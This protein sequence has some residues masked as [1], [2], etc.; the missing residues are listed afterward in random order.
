[1]LKNSH[2]RPQAWR[3]SGPRVYYPEFE[4]HLLLQCPD[5]LS[6]TFFT[7]CTLQVSMFYPNPVVFDIV[8]QRLLDAGAG[9]CNHVV[10]EGDP[11]KICFPCRTMPEVVIAHF[12]ACQTVLGQCIG[13]PRACTL[14]ASVSED[15]KQSW[16]HVTPQSKSPFSIQLYSNTV[17]KKKSVSLSGGSGLPM[18]VRCARRETTTGYRSCPPCK[19][20]PYMSRKLM[21]G[22][23][24]C[25]KKR[26]GSWILDS[27][28][29]PL[30]PDICILLLC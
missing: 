12:Y 7:T 14:C 23:F 21:S 20:N 5:F 17:L 25:N 4:Y 16:Y 28:R 24:I 9:I 22:L 13:D 1:M 10:K 27:I 29:T 30:G 26:G 11:H 19:T 18:V 15:V 6:G 3:L 2:F 8:A